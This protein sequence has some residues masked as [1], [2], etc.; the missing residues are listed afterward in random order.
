MKNLVYQ[1]LPGLGKTWLATEFNFAILDTDIV[2]QAYDNLVV[3]DYDRRPHAKAVA[4]STR[5]IRK[6]SVLDRVIVTNLQWVSNGDEWL[7]VVGHNPDTY[8]SRLRDSD[9]GSDFEIFSDD[10]LYGWAV[11][12]NRIATHVIESDAFVADV[13]KLDY[14]RALQQ[15]YVSSVFDAKKQN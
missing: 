7:V 14:I 9:R 1:A 10:E 5:A 3:R 11:H 13:V 12:T 4:A 8:V 2:F 6:Q 15:E